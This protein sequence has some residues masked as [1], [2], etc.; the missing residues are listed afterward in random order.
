VDIGHAKACRVEFNE[1]IIWTWDGDG[2]I[3]DGDV[4]VGAF[5]DDD[6]GFAV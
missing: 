4:E 2:N 3:G 1:D 5:I 6:A